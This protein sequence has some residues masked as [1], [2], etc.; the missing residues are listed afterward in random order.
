MSLFVAVLWAIQVVNWITGYGLNP[1][2]GLIPRYLGGLDGVIAM[3]LLHGSFGHLMA[4][5]PPLLVMG[6]LLV[7]TTT[8]ALLPVNAVV[9]GLG[10]ALVWLL[11]SSAI[12]IGASG[13][14]FGWFG[15]LV[16]RGLVDRSLITLGAALV[17]GVLYGSVLWGVLSGPTRRVLGSAPL[18]RHRRRG[19]C[20]PGPN[21]CPCPALGRRRSGLSATTDVPGPERSSKAPLFAATQLHQTGHSSI[22]QHSRTAKVGTADKPA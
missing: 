10:G 13:L 5:T 14:V 22:M 9:I 15:F 1:A 21:A 20:V 12:H 2:F 8:R 6:G 3:P 19:R 18:R 17:V 16:V 4:N 7:A 11:G